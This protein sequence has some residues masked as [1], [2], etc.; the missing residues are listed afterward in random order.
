MAKVDTTK[1]PGYEEM[2]AEEK[3]NAVLSYEVEVETNPNNNL[4]AERLKAAF[5]KA[6]SEAAEY[7]RQLRAKQ[8]DEEVKAAQIAEEA[9]KAAQEREALLKKVEALQAEKS[10]KEYESAYLALGYDAETANANAKALHSGEFD[11]VFAN[12]KKFIEAQRKEAVAANL[13]N[14]PTLTTGNPVSGKDA[15]DAAMA[16][17]RKHFGL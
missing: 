16:G 9:A 2:S 7:K 10:I 17:L 11:K 4:E 8:T 5:D 15:E 6:S 12:Q 14:Q 13:K 3:L 1:I